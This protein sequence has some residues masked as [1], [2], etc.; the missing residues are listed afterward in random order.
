LSKLDEVGEEEYNRFYDSLKFSMKWEGGYVNDPKDSGGETKWGISKLSYPDEDIPN[1]TPQ[2]AAE[3]YYEDYWQKS[4]ANF[5]SYPLCAVVFD[6]AILCGVGR[7]IRWLRESKGDSVSLL[8]LRRIHHVDRVKKKP[9]QK[10]FLAG[11]LNRVNDLLKL[12]EIQKA[13]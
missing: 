2:R 10:R 3:I 1:L 7:A 11:W 12:L 8:N 4:G 5:L 13:G 9:D 6:T